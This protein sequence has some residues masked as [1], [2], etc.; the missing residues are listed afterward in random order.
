M[1]KQTPV[2]ESV[3]ITQVVTLTAQAQYESLSLIRVVSH[4]VIL[5]VAVNTKGLCGNSGKKIQGDKHS[6]G[7]SMKCTLLYL[8]GLFLLAVWLFSRSAAI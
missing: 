7:F 1:I 3:R 8:L 4:C 6:L 5:K 2:N